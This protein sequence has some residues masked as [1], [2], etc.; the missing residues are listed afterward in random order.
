[1]ERISQKVVHIHASDNDGLVDNNQPLTNETFVLFDKLKTFNNL[2]CLILEVSQ[3]SMTRIQEQINLI[4]N[5]FAV[6]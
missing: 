2:K 5:N 6:V 4:R 1:M 3:I